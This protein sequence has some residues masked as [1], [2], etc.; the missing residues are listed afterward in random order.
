MSAQQLSDLTAEVGMRIPRSVLANLESGRRGNVG[1]HELLVLAAALNVSPG[2]LLFP[3]GYGDSVEV[4]P[5]SSTDPLVAIHWLGGKR[6]APRLKA[7]VSNSPVAALE[8]HE[9]LVRQIEGGIEYRDQKR[10][11]YV[12]AMEGRRE[13]LRRID[14]LEGEASALH[15]LVSAWRESQRDTNLAD[16]PERPPQV[17]DA[18]ASLDLIAAEL[19]TLKESASQATFLREGVDYADDRLKALGSRLARLRWDIDSKGWLVPDLP[20]RV[21]R[22]VVERS[23]SELLGFPEDEPSD[24]QE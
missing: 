1:V 13:T 8:W 23:T 3:V 10:H 17:A 12:Q 2:Q 21:A 14:R 9:S 5:G 19:K 18:F 15:S 16:R 6:L 20:N 22:F 11:E 4:L 7:S 24:D